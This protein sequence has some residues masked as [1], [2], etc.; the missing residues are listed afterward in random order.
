MNFKES[1]AL[2][3]ELKNDFAYIGDR[4]TIIRKDLGLS[5][6]KLSKLI[7]IPQSNISA[8]EKTGRSLIMGSM[9]D[10]FLSEGYNL[11]WIISR[12]NSNFSKKLEAQEISVKFVKNH[13]DSIDNNLSKMSE[14]LTDARN[15][16]SEV[17]G[18]MG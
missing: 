7:N 16:N 1:M 2:E 4:C 17:K 15:E 8:L 3:N 10:F 11:N 13:L 12:D 18:K 14:L 5:Q 6:A 9:F